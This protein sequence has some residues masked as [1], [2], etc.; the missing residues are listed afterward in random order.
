MRYRRSRHPISGIAWPESLRFSKLGGHD[1]RCGP[2]GDLRAFTGAFVLRD[3]RHRADGQFQVALQSIAAH[4][5][6][7]PAYMS[8][9]W[10]LAPRLVAQ[11]VVRSSWLAQLRLL[12]CEY[13]SALGDI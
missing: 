10:D 5:W 4:L 7:N 11:F 13:P 12:Q 3:W 9:P 1:G 6:R 2:V 8:L